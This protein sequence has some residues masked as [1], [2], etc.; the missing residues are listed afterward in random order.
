MELTLVSVIS[1]LTGLVG[2]GFGIKK[3]QGEITKASLDN[4]LTQITI[5]ETIID[6]LREEISILITKIDDQ[7][8]VIKHLES[9]VECLMKNS[10]V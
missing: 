5:Y 1:I 2:F 3:K 4:I 7:E 6:D 8:K 10:E 9:R